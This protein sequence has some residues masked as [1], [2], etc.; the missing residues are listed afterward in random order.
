MQS[1]TQG[2]IANSLPSADDRGKVD[3]P[4][5]PSWGLTFDGV[6]ASRM[7]SLVGVLRMF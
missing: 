7:S 2:A 3:G 1:Y 4:I 6:G 5:D